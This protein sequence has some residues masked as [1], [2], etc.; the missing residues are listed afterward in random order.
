MNKFLSI[1]ILALASAQAVAGG[2]VTSSDGSIVKTGSDLCL[3]TGYYT[4]TDAVKGCDAVPV[5]VA[6]PVPVT[7]NS[8][9]LFAF[10]SA[11]LT[12]AG[13]AALDALATQ[14]AGQAFVEGHTDRIG[15]V[16]YNKTLSSARAKAVADYL[17]T[18]TKATFVVSGVG[19]S[20][21][22]G[23]TAECIGPMSPQL[24]ACLAPDRRVVITIIK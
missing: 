3:H 19:S 14:V 13:K 6:K 12:V 11:K 21:P 10:D 17:S 9:V 1:V 18:K 5:V 22:S 24:I 8:D 4:A 2:Y 16:G 15:T 7:L 20:Q 23:K